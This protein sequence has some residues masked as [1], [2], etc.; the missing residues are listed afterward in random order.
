MTAMTH[1]ASNHRPLYC[2]EFSFLK[3][4][5]VF[6]SRRPSKCANVIEKASQVALNS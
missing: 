5:L 1:K 4:V 3:K 6:T 2:H